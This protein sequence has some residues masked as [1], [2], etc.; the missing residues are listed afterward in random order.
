[1]QSIRRQ[2]INVGPISSVRK[3]EAIRPAASIS[4]DGISFAEVLKE[5]IKAS[6]QDESQQGDLSSS[7]QHAN[8][9][10]KESNANR[11]AEQHASPEST[12]SGEPIVKGWSPFG[13]DSGV[14]LH[15]QL[16]SLLNKKSALIGIA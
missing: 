8:E 5:A 3:A 2:R 1:M 7:P 16:E 9:C 10:E 11:P 13:D 12:A 4:S 15:D 6:Q 14:D